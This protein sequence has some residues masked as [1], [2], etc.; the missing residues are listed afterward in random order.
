MVRI[1]LVPLALLFGACASGAGQE[2]GGLR[3]TTVAPGTLERAF[4]PRRFALIVGIGD[5]DDERWRDLRYASRDAREL[6]SALTPTDGRRFDRVVVLTAPQETGRDRILAALDELSTLATRPDDVVVIYFSTHGTLARD[7]TGELRRYLVARDSR[8]RDVP[9]TALGIDA[10]KARLDRFGSRRRLLVLAACHSGSGKSL[11]PEDVARE[12][13]GIKSGFYARP[14][15]DVS[16]A[17]MVLSASD[18][19]E[20]AREDDQLQHDI[21]THFLLAA[22]KG[23]GDRNGDGA[24]SA[25]EAHDY[26]RRRTFAFTSGR[27]RPSAEVL[28]VGADPILLAGRIHRSGAPEL[29]SYNPRLDGFTLKV[30]GE[31]RAEL[32]GGTAVRAGKRKIELT[33]GAE[34]LFSRSVEIALGQRMDLEALIEASEPRRTVFLTGGGFTF[35]DAR[36]RREIL[37]AAATAGLS[38]R[39]DGLP[40]R[41]VS[42]WTDLAASGGKSSLDLGAEAGAVRFSFAQATAGVAGTYSWRSGRF[43]LFGG[44]RVEGHWLRRSFQLPAVSAIDGSF[45]VAPGVTIGMSWMVNDWFELSARGNAAWSRLRVDGQDRATG[46]ASGWVAAGYRF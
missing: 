28:E 29:Y 40:W 46:M 12:L 13:E 10:V 26:A 45:A 35:L 39:W 41:G 9:G 15:E 23:E 33:K 31:P 43:R 27:Q 21:Y 37:P 4:E 42:V 17:A 32:P 25:Y 19:G 44:P 22:L 6:A 16:R 34:T 7:S 14:L 18:W 36:S 5:F 24:V 11:L 38:M 1:S 30:D 3:P 8:F 2:K 20:T